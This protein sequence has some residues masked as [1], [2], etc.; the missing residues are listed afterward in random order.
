M[1][2]T[3]VTID[4]I[5]AASGFTVQEVQIAVIELTLEEKI[6]RQS[7]QKVARIFRS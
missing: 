1:G 7:G 2:K 4:N 6:E 5:V 3:P